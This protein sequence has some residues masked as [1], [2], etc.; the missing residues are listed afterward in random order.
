MVKALAQLGITEPVKVVNAKVPSRGF[1]VAPD[2]EA[3]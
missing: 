1:D 2:V 3:D